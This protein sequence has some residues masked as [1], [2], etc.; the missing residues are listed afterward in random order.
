M[1]PTPNPLILLIRGDVCSFAL[2]RSSLQLR[3]R[4]PNLYRCEVTGNAP[5]TRARL[6]R[7]RD[8]RV[9]G[10]VCGGLAEYLQVDVVITRIIA[11]ALLAT[12]SGFLLY[13]VAWIII[14]EAPKTDVAP[15][16]SMPVRTP[17]PHRGASSERSRWLLGGVLIAIGGWWM[18]RNV[19]DNLAP[20]LD[21]LILPMALIAIGTAVVV[22]AMKK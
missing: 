18:I 10:G 13:I 1:R 12:G 4:S 19:A 20:W 11:V 22:Y 9:I 15:G 14:P 6:Y 8:V 2:P 21:D 17:P 16:I 7:S 5:T 3:G